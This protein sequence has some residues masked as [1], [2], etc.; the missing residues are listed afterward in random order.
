MRLNVVGVSSCRFFP[1]LVAD[2]TSS[3]E[4]HSLKKTLRPCTSSHF[5]SKWICVDLPEPSSPSTAMSRPGKLSSANV[6]RCIAIV[7]KGLTVPC[8]SQLVQ[9]DDAGNYFE[10]RGHNLNQKVLG[11]SIIHQ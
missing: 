7:A 10:D 3:E 6:F 9:P 4:F 8:A 5:L 1:L 11:G 2:F